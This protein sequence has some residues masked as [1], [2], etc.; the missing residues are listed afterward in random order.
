[1]MHHDTIQAFRVKAFATLGGVSSSS[2][3]PCSV[4]S[5]FDATMLKN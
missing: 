5:E 3:V 4:F 1:M 2:K